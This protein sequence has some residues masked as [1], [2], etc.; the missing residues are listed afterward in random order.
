MT[1]FLG[2]DTVSVCNWIPAFPHN[3]TTQSPIQAVPYPRKTE[4]SATPHQKQNFRT[5]I[6]H[7]YQHIH[8][9]EINLLLTFDMRICWYKSM[10]TKATHGINQ[11]NFRTVLQLQ[12]DIYAKTGG[13]KE[14]GLFWSFLSPQECDPC[15]STNKTFLPSAVFQTKFISQWT[16]FQNNINTKLK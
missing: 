5:V 11:I 16:N 3:V 12:M 9:T 15:Y 8:I 2:C 6:I 13:W 4:C 7:L 10:I 14:N 1:S